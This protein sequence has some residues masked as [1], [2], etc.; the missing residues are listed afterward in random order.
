MKLSFKLSI[1][2]FLLLG[3]QS[4][5]AQEDSLTK[6][7]QNYSDLKTIADKH[8]EG[9]N[10]E[11][12]KA[13][14]DSCKKSDGHEFDDYLIGQIE[15]SGRCMGYLRA[16]DE[17]CKD[18]TASKACLGLYEK[19]LDINPKDSTAKKAII[20]TYWQEANRQYQN[21]DF[22]RAKNSFQKTADYSEQSLSGKAKMLIDS[23]NYFIERSQT[24]FT[25][26]EVDSSASYV[27]GLRGINE[28][29]GSNM[30]YPQKAIDAKV[31]GKVWVSFI[32]SE[33]GKILP[34]S[35][36][37]VKGIG[38]GC[39]EEAVR[40]VK[41]MNKWNPALKKGYPVRF[42]YTLPIQFVIK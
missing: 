38:S 2:L 5:L 19:I 23:C 30:E 35:V 9:G 3:Y 31:S 36:K 42:Q 11:L 21:W 6:L 25:M 37:A 8:F 20:Y 33:K 1:C 27:S 4:I 34:E 40:L 28:V 12:A 22:E 10:Y 16:I 41:L 39:D 24:G 32:I 7:N 18:N 13:L 14:Y 29:I 17:I 26:I 15:S